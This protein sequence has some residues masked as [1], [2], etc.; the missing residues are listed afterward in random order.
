MNKAMQDQ[1]APALVTPLSERIG[2]KYPLV[3]APMFLISNPAMLIAAARAGILGAMPSLNGRSNEQFREM[4]AQVKAATDAPFAINMTIGLTDPE[5]LEAD[6]QACIDYGVKVL[7]TSYGD[8][9][10]IVERAHRHGMIV[11]HDV[12]SLRHARK[13]QAAGVDAVIGVSAGAGGHAGSISPMAFIPWLS[14]ELDVPVAAAGCIGS[15]AQ[16]LSALGLGAQLCYMGTRFIACEES[17]AVADYKAMLA[18][19]TPEDIVYT[20]AVSGIPAN[21]LRAT[22]PAQN[23]IDEQSTRKRWR[24]IWSAGQGVAQI[25]QAPAMQD[26][27][28]DVM[29]GYYQSLARLQGLSAREA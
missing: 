10:P 25:H 3:C 19:A 13:A 12:V 27:V 20:D 17:P 1:Q 6:L 26:I 24:D 22:L 8:P 14:D 2:L 21:F 11:M 16:V 5:R 4:L 28:Q 15:G 18:D 9:T 7:I 29:Q 23:A